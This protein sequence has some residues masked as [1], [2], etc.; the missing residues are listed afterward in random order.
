VRRTPPDG[1]ADELFHDA[2]MGL[3]F[4][5][6]ASVIRRRRR[7]SSGSMRSAREMPDQ[8]SEK[9]GDD[10]AL[11]GRSAAGAPLRRVSELPQAR[12]KRESGEL[13]RAGSARQG[14]RGATRSAEA[15]PGRVFAQFG[16]T[17]RLAVSRVYAA[18]GRHRGEPRCAAT[19]D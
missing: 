14:E 5:L 19:T 18:L 8:V 12:Q 15:I 7:T 10:A 9:H 11:G 13:E 4:L 6:Q 1:V 2:A 3:N 16:H 17:G